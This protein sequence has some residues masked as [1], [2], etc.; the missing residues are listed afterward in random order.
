MKYASDK[1]ITNLLLAGSLVLTA[2]L[3]AEWLIPFKVDAMDAGQSGAALVDESPTGARSRYLHPHI[4]KYSEI[5]ARPIFFSNRQLPREAVTRAQAPSVPLRL[6]LEGIAIAAD[7]RVAV[8]RDQ[9]SNQLVQMS[10]GMS[11]NDWLLEDITST[12]ATFSRSDDVTSISL[13]SENQ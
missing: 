5:L 8:L 2:M 9:G 1:P 6:K 11:R 3:V 12:T 13:N 10:V 7:V 4:G